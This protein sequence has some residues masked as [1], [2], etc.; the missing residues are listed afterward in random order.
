MRE[1]FRR[2]A[3]FSASWMGSSYA[4]AA[5]ALII[6]VWALTGPMFHFSDTW[7][8]VINTGTTVI[9]FLMVFI[10]QYTQIRDTQAMQLKLDELL[11]AVEAAR[12]GMIGLEDRSDERLQEIKKDFESFAEFEGPE[13]KTV[14]P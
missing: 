10:I 11:R 5:G 7:Q 6:V 2:F 4:F 12:N 14:K 1:H 13:E 8:L 9:T 3:V